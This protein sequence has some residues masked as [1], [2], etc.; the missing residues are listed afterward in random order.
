MVSSPWNV[1]SSNWIYCP[2]NVASYLL[3]LMEL[4]DAINL[5]TYGMELLKYYF[6]TASYNVCVCYYCKVLILL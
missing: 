2:S 5:Q 1:V 4:K 6:Y 3:K